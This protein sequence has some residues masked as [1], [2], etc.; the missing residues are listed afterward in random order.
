MTEVPTVTRH[1]TTGEGPP[2]S[3][4]KIVCEGKDSGYLRS[5]TDI[6]YG[7]KRG[8]VDPVLLSPFTPPPPVTT[9]LGVDTPIVFFDPWVSKPFLYRTSVGVEGH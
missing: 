2:V 1:V 3:S 7:R 6:L 8:E 5:D 4:R 9:S